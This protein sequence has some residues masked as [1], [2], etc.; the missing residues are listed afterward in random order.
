MRRQRNPSRGWTLLLGLLAV[1]GGYYWY[2]HRAVTQL[3][4]GNKYQVA[5]GAAAVLGVA[6]LGWSSDTQFTTAPGGGTATILGTYTGSTTALP[7]GITA[8]A[9]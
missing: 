8:N 4:P 2:T 5:G 6:A 1:G 7:A 9:A 3:V